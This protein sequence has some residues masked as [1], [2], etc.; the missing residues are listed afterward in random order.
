M[1]Q[2]ISYLAIS[3][4]HIG[5]PKTTAAEIVE[6]LDDYFHAFGPTC[7]FNDINMLFIVGD[8][9]DDSIDLASNVL[10]VFLPWFDRLLSWAKRRDIIIIILEGTP[11]HDRKQ[12]ATL[13]SIISSSL[14]KPDCRYVPS[15]SI[16]RIEE[17]DLTVLYVPDKCRPTAEATARDVQTLLDEQGLEKVDIAMMHGMFRYQLGTIPMNNQ[18][19]DERFFL[20][21]VKNY[22]SIGHVHTYS[23]YERIVAQGSFDRLTHG[24]EE[25][26]GAV[27]FHRIDGEWSY[28]F[29]ENTKAKK[30]VDLAVT[31]DVDDMMK[32]ISKLTDKLPHGSS[33]R[34]VGDPLHPIYQG[35]STLAIKYPFYV[36][37]TKKA[38]KDERDAA[39]IVGDADDYKPV[40]LNRNTITEAVH[41]EVSLLNDLNIAE[42]TRLHQLLEQHHERT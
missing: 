34:L 36:F 2:D 8:L 29:V 11:R 5:H 18:V 22:I 12:S 41:Q 24:Q 25:P 17:Y 40:I 13:M 32:K 6:H 15:L 16:Q 27:L 7:P 21:R 39:P 23:T 42:S 4:V 26:K 31:G 3:D 37:E 9:W 10:G 1:K 30:Y 14:H 33:I 38:K 19:H 20:D 28:R 35:L